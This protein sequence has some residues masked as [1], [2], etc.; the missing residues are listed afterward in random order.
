MHF[1]EDVSH[2]TTLP[3]RLAGLV[4][5]GITVTAYICQYAIVKTG[6]NNE[7]IIWIA[8]QACAALLRII[9]WT[10]GTSFEL[11]W[12]KK[13]EYAIINNSTSDVISLIEVLA[14]CTQDNVEIPQWAWTYLSTTPFWHILKASIYNTHNN[15]IP[16]DASHHIFHNVSISRLIENRRRTTN[17]EDSNYV[18]NTM[19]THIWT[20]A[21]WM[22]RDNVVR[23][24]IVIP[25][26]FKVAE[27]QTD[28]CFVQ[29]S[30]GKVDTEKRLIDPCNM[31]ACDYTGQRL[32]I[33]PFRTMTGQPASSACIHGCH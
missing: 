17:K 20:L 25:M 10:F 18:E 33:Q 29:A 7:V 21:F 14:A 6:S 27:G 28:E 30:T 11:P 22:D 8:A 12:T 1:Q 31:F 26:E 23:P 2:I 19:W 16:R 9:Y 4:V 15:H 24:F 3:V 32:H 5:A 13:A